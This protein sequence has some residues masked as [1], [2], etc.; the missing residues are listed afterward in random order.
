VVAAA[1]TAHPS[2]PSTPLTRSAAGAP[3]SLFG[4]TLS[5]IAMSKEEDNPFVNVKYPDQVGPPMKDEHFL[6]GS[7]EFH[8]AA[9]LLKMEEVEKL[10]AAGNADVDTGDV[11]NQTPLLLLARNH[12]DPPDVPK[13]VAMVEKVIAAGATVTVDGKIRRDQYGDSILH[14]A[15]MAS[16]KNGPTIVEALVKALPAADRAQLCSAR[17]KNFGNTALHWATLGGDDATCQVLINAGARLDRKNRL[18]ESVVDYAVKYE[19]VKMKVKYE[20]LMAA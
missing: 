11:L 16:G 9:A 10:L 12:Y 1:P 19:R 14:L 4:R 20:S 6:R 15:A 7:T 2:P 13:A 8:K 17:C 5:P 18:K 3:A